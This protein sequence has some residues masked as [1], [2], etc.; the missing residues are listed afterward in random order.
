MITN[1]DGRSVA[2]DLSKHG[3]MA[4]GGHFYSYRL[5][6]GLNLDPEAGALRVSFVHYTSPGDIEKL[7]K[8]MDAVL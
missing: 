3:I 5:F 4:A 8:A 1:R 6:Q 7:L 2:A